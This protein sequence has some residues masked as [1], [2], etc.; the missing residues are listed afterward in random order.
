MCVVS[1]RTGRLVTDTFGAPAQMARTGLTREQYGRTSST[2]GGVIIMHNHPAS[3]RPSYKDLRSVAAN[4]FVKASLVLCHDGS[5][6][7]I[8]G[9]SD[10]LIR[11]YATIMDEYEANFGGTIPREQIEMKALDELYRRNGAEKW[12]RVK[13][14]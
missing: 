6:Y 9:T 3:T 5:V 7:A 13:K 11:A 10:Q 12:L 1:W 4:D 8:S 2:G 14:L